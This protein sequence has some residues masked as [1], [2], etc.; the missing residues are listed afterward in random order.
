MW[1][2]F[3]ERFGLLFLELFCHWKALK[4]L[5]F[6]MLSGNHLKAIWKQAKLQANCDRTWK[7]LSKV[8]LPWSSEVLRWGFR[9]QTQRFPPINIELWGLKNELS[10]D[11]DDSSRV[12]RNFSM[13]W[14]SFLIQSVDSAVKAM[15]CEFRALYML[16]QTEHTK[17]VKFTQIYNH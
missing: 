6:K 13:N 1:L 8:R 7:M 5:K 4:R 17:W 9:P 16:A 12:G 14:T 2:Y 3:L 15:L 10:N 11:F